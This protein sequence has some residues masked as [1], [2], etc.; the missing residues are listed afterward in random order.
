V[1]TLVLHGD[2][3]TLID[4]SGGVRTA[5]CIAGARFLSIEGMGHDLAP[6]Y[7]PLI[8]DEI[9]AHAHSATKRR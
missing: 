5:Q 6:R 1:P 7:W 3:D 8:V 9:T 2:A 4:L